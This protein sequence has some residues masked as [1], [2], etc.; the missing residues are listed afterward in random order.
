MIQ[1]IATWSG[2]IISWLSNAAR[3]V[4]EPWRNNTLTRAR[5]AVGYPSNC[6]TFAPDQS[7]ALCLWNDVSSY[8]ISVI[9]ADTNCGK[10]LISWYDLRTWN[11]TLYFVSFDRN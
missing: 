11:L 6:A 8:I 10:I 5:E 9:E 2:L 4:N 7:L 3:S 1:K